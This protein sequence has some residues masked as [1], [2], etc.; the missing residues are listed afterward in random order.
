MY[1]AHLI[2]GARL[3][4]PPTSHVP[5][6]FQMKR[7]LEAD[8]RQ[9]ER[10]WY[11]TEEFGGVAAPDG[12]AHNPFVGDQKFFEVR[13][14]GGAGVEIGPLPSHHAHED[15]RGVKRGEWIIR[16]GGGIRCLEAAIIASWDRE[17]P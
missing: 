1:P 7:E 12:D 2:D 5:H 6:T 10:D 4:H 17:K 15:G 8:E 13:G 9:L 11:D 14:G 16:S 3:L